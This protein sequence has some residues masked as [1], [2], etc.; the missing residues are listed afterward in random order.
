MNS[1]PKGS[2]IMQG[3]VKVGLG[4]VPLAAALFRHAV[5]DGSSPKRMIG[6]FMSAMALTISSTRPP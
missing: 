2:S 5:Q 4:I 3:R 1:F 6:F